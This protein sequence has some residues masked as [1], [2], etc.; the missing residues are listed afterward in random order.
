MSEV[1]KRRFQW[2]L[3]LSREVLNHPSGLIGVTV[4][5]FL[6]LIVLLA[7]LISPYDPVAQ[8][9]SSILRPPS[10]SHPFGTDQYGRDIMSRIFWGSRV[11][12]AGGLLTVLI[13]SLIGTT[14]GLIAGFYEGIVSYVIMRLTDFFLAFPSLLL[15]VLIAATIGPGL[16][17]ATLALVVSWWPWY[18]RLVY[19]QVLA[20]KQE[21]YIEAVRAIGASSIRIIFKHILPQALPPV[22]V[23][24]T[25]DLSYALLSMATLSF[26]GLGTQ[27]PTPE[28]GVMISEARGYLLKGCWWLFLWPGFFLLLS[29]VCFIML[30]DALN[31]ILNPKIVTAMRVRRL[32]L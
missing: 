11:T 6:I 25:M 10:W 24:F 23:Q 2:L 14:L 18:S 22:L 28:W 1:L 26:I 19:G 13:A 31:D 5:I 4:L 17:N 3:L 20:I 7:P 21:P 32:R 27:P 12:F 15:A 9:W 8:D 30:G 29:I 16:I